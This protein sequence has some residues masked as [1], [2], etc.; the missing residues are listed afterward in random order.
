MVSS[1]ET[2]RPA[3]PS[4]A[5]TSRAIPRAS[6]WPS[7][8]QAI[9][10]RWLSSDT[11][12]GSHRPRWLP[13]TRPA[14]WHRRRS[15]PRRRPRYSATPTGPRPC[16]GPGSAACTSPRA[17]AA[18]TAFINRAFQRGMGLSSS[19]WAMGHSGAMGRARPT[20]LTPACTSRTTRPLAGFA[21]RQLA[22][23]PL[24]KASRRR[25]SNSMRSPPQNSSPWQTNDGA[26]NTPSACALWEAIAKSLCASR[27]R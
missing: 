26:P 19:A 11:R 7:S 6:G 21:A 20:T 4:P 15:R 18:S 23:A 9:S 13:G 24:R 3:L 2:G 25:A 8:R 1:A 10:T 12:A 22:S 27:C 17:V 16:S 14:R 5:T